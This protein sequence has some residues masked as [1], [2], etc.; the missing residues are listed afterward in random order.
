MA[1]YQEA[2][3]PLRRQFNLAFFQRLFIDDEYTVTGELAEPFDTLLG[4][5]LRR[6][7]AVRANEQLQ[8]AV[9]QTIRKRPPRAL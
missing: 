4:D 9:E 7:V 2:S 6:A 1:A 3:G 5:E 8:D